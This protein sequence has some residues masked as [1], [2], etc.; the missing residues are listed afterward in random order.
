MMQ[1]KIPLLHKAIC[2]LDTKGIVWGRPPPAPSSTR[3]AL[4]RPHSGADSRLAKEVLNPF[5]DEVI[6][7]PLLFVSSIQEPINRSMDG[8]NSISQQICSS[9]S[10]SASSAWRA[11]SVMF[12]GRRIHNNSTITRHLDVG[13][14]SPRID[15]RP[16]L[17]DDGSARPRLSFDD[18]ER[19]N[20]AIPSLEV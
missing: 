20:N 16:G 5:S 13:S 10:A 7:I 18:W 11:R 4:A 1:Q 12:V 15:R 14:R 6:A 17:N 19:R 2:C 8:K 9:S 3:Q